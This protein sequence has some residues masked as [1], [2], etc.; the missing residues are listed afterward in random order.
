MKRTSFWVPIL[1]IISGLFILGCQNPLSIPEDLLAAIEEETLG[2]DTAISEEVASGG[3]PTLDTAGPVVTFVNPTEGGMVSGTMVVS[4]TAVDASS[5][6]S[7]EYNLDSGG[8]TTIAG[9][10]AFWSFSINT[11]IDL[12]TGAH[13]IQARATDTLGQ[14]SSVV[15]VNFIVDQAVPSLTITSPTSGALLQGSIT[16][17]GTASDSNGIDSVVIN[18]DQGTKYYAATGT[19]SWTYPFDSTT[20]SDGILII[21]VITTD[22]SGLTRIVNVAVIVDNTAPTVSITS[23]T[24]NEPVSGIIAFSGTASDAV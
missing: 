5:I 1:I 14:A 17:E 12:D 4:G 3:G 6:Q 9:G 15:T 2:V 7:V 19:T 11:L 13:Q 22:N 23:H 18:P 16:I 10:G 24:D 8:W 21:S 20:A